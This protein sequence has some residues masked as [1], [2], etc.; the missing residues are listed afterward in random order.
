MVPSN[1]LFNKTVTIKRTSQTITASG[2][3]DE[4][5]VTTEANVPCRIVLNRWYGTVDIG[6]EGFSAVGTH[7]IFTKIG[8]YVDDGYYAVDDDTDDTYRVNLVDKFPGGATDTHYE[9]FVTKVDS[10]S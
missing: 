8:V 1:H 6:D 4:E 3:T 9:L 5:L 2:D 7:R 10:V